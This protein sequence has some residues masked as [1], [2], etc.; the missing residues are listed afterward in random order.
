MGLVVE[1]E[2]DV[3]CIYGTDS[4][5]SSIFCAIP[6]CHPRFLKGETF[7]LSFFEDQ[8]ALVHVKDVQVF[9]DY[10][11]KKCSNSKGIRNYGS[12]AWGEDVSLPWD[13]AFVQS[14]Q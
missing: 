13:P 1:K 7:H 9:L 2:P 3:I 10:S 5:N 12:D 8:T 11:A 14:R 4:A 6:L